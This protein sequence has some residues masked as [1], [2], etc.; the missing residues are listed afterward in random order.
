[1]QKLGK[2]YLD[3]EFGTGDLAPMIFTE[4]KFVPLR[5]EHL[6]YKGVFE[7]IG[8]SH[9]FAEIRHGEQA[10]EYR[11]VITET[12]GDDGEEPTFEVEAVSI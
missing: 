1:M 8:L 4:L 9:Q 10:P 5:V 12:P 3:T 6:A 11:I 7:Y 2:F